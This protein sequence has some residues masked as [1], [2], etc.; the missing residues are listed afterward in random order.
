VGKRCELKKII[1]ISVIIIVLLLLAIRFTGCEENT[2]YIPQKSNLQ[3]AQEVGQ[4]IMD[5]FINKDEEAL[6]SLLSP[7]AK[8]YY[9]TRE[10]IKTAFDFIDGEI[11]SYDLPS[12][13]GGGGESIEKGKVVSKNMTP[14]ITNI[15]TDKG[16]TYRISFRYNFIVNGD[17]EE[18]GVRNI[19]ISWMDKG[20]N[21]DGFFDRIAIGIDIDN[22][23]PVNVVS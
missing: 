6:Y 1:L 2:N 21:V 20:S 17:S 23:N 4:E 5:A 13:T 10:Q 7:N 22:N 19:F 3:I 14:R 9:M 16:K 18:K 15:K 8:E 12:K 11:I